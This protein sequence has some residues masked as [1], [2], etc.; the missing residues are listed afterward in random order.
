MQAG[1]FEGREG[2]NGRGLAATNPGYFSTAPQRAA[3]A[4]SNTSL[5]G[6][7]APDG[8]SLE[9]Y[10]NKLLEKVQEG[11]GE[12]IMPRR[13]TTLNPRRCTTLNYLL[14]VVPTAGHARTLAF[15]VALFQ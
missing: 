3:A 5:D 14:N 8:S 15:K 13:C 7:T 1:V 10:V 9:D 2:D 4:S 11:A 12:G 6:M